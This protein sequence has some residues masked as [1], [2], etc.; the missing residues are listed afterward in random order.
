MIV[1]E[2][3]I[4][5]PENEV[6]DDRKEWNVRLPPIIVVFIWR[7]SSD[8]PKPRNDDQRSDDRYYLQ[9]WELIANKVGEPSIVSFPSQ[10]V[11]KLDEDDGTYHTNVYNIHVKKDSKSPLFDVP[12][13]PECV[14]KDKE[15]G[16]KNSR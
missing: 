8:G 2:V 1:P 4:W 12:I 9:D 16:L 11:G 15:D 3:T 6:R 10:G 5:V 14:S 7:A 13:Y